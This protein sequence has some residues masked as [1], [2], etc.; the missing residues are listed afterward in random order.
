MTKASDRIRQRTSPKRQYVSVSLSIP[1]DVCEDLTAMA[2]LRGFTSYK[3][4]MRAYI[5]QALRNDLASH[6]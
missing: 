2:K 3:A 5:G 1:E 6:T 4:L